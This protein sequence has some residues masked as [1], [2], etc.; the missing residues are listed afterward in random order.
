MLIACFTPSSRD[1][2]YE[3]ASASGSDI[4][5]FAALEKNSAKDLVALG[6]GQSKV[7]V[8]CRSGVEERVPVPT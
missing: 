5:R 8:C 7:V 4:H 1:H 6:R 2:P 3:P